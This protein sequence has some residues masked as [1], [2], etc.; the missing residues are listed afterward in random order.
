MAILGGW[1]IPTL[2][3]SF[4]SLLQYASLRGFRQ[5]S[6]PQARN[7]Q[8]R[9]VSVA[10]SVSGN[11]LNWSPKKEFFSQQTTAQGT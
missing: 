4:G 9:R 3:P 8:S 2:V 1:T 7:V 10:D 5:T 6:C 11:S